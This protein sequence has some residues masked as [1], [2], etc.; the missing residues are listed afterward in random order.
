MLALRS[1]ELDILGI[2]VVSGNVPAKKGASNAQK[3][4]HWMNRPDIPVYLGEELPLVRPYVDAM[5]THGEDG[6]GESKS[7][8]EQSIR[9]VWAFLPVHCMKLP[10]RRS[11]FRSL[12]W[13]L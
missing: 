6:L 5:D 4:L 11:R 12:L 7:Q 2:T 13:D 3:V 9:M 8:M 10:K 1:P